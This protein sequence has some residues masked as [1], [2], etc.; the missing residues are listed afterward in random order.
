MYVPYLF[1]FYFKCD[2]RTGVSYFGNEEYIQIYSR[3]C[4][5]LVS[6]STREWDNENQES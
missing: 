2:A 1:Y 4:L 6:P 3:F 5:D